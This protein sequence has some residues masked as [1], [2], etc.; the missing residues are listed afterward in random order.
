MTPGALPPLRP[1][2]VDVLRAAGAIAR[3]GAPAPYDI[4][5]NA[6]TGAGKTRIGLECGLIHL[7]ADPRRVVG[8]FAHRDE[9]IEQPLSKLRAYGVDVAVIRAGEPVRAGARFYI[10]S[11]Q[12][13]LARG[14]A[15]LPV[16]TLP[17]LDEARH[18][19]A[20]EWFEIARA[21]CEGRSRIGLDAT[22]T[23]DMRPLFSHVVRGPT[24]ASL[25]AE[26]HLVY[27]LH[28]GPDEEVAELSAHPLDAYETHLRGLRA[29]IFA[30]SVAIAQQWVKEAR[31]RGFTAECVE[32]QMAV[33]R[34]RAAIANYLRGAVDILINVFCLTEGSDLPPT[35]GIII[36]RGCG[37]ESTWVQMGGRGMRPWPGKSLVR[38]VDLYGTSW[39]LGFLWEE[40]EWAIDGTAP[41]RDSALPPVSKC[42]QCGA[43]G[44]PFST[45]PGCGFRLPPPA[46]P[47]IAP[48][49]IGEMKREEQ[50]RRRKGGEQWER[51]CA[52]VW[53]GR[54]KGWKGQ[55]A[56]MRFKTETG[57]FPKWR[58]DH[59]PAEPM[60]G[61][62]GGERREAS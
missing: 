37:N 32:G 19:L 36:A 11:I 25:I 10:V 5:I 59:V 35:E 6:A 13:A 31:A 61:P 27:P 23:G 18:Y 45:C 4:L 21:V 56:A 60:V 51:W 41:R 62:L 54:R 8:W 52:L 44:P 39:R 34:R 46:P 48:R 58:V 42:R 40:R 53:E 28:I 55:A 57:R 29:I 30:P 15:A 16:F 2:Q 49:P 33:E 50:D 38:F 26:G 7:A 24:I 22:P 17:I 12:T 43:W 14:L 3:Q 20:P 47:K 1:Y 9:L